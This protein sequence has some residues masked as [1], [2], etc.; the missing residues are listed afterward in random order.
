MR[1]SIEKLWELITY[2][3]RF[4]GWFTWAG[5]FVGSRRF[6]SQD[7]VYHCGNCDRRFRL[8][9]QYCPDCGSYRIERIR[10]DELIE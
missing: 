9:R 7:R 4:T 6:E 10:Y 5:R 2:G 3:G 1:S 8:N